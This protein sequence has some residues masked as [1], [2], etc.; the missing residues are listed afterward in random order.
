M[1][2]STHVVKIFLL[3]HPETMGHR[4]DL[5]D[6]PVRFLFVTLGSFSNAEVI[7]PLL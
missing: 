1:R 5:T 7:A 4:G 6:K 2:K 3:G